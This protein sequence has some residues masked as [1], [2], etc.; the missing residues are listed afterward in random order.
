[1]QQTK[2]DKDD[3]VRDYPRQQLWVLALYFTVALFPL[4]GV[5]IADNAWERWLSLT[6]IALAVLAYP[7]LVTYFLISPRLD[8]MRD[9]MDD[10]VKS[11]RRSEMPRVSSQELSIQLSRTAGINEQQAE[12]VIGG[13]TAILAHVAKKPTYIDS[14]HFPFP[15]AVTSEEVECLHWAVEHATGVPSKMAQRLVQR[16]AAVIASLLHDSIHVGKVKAIEIY[17]IGL[18]ERSYNGQILFFSQKHVIP[19][20]YPDLARRLASYDVAGERA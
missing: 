6:T 13:L 5:L 10:I 19:E 11:E 20:L 8:A 1:M 12:A 2:R 16:T 17:P 4:F 15:I 9:E 3:S 18:Y 7:M 14:L